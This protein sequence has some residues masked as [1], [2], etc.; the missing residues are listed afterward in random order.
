MRSKVR[1]DLEAHGVDTTTPSQTRKGMGGKTQKI[2][3][4]VETYS[5]GNK[6]DKWKTKRRKNKK[7]QTEYKTEGSTRKTPG[8][9]YEGGWSA[10]EQ[11]SRGKVSRMLHAAKG[12][13][14]P[15]KIKMAKKRYK[16]VSD[17]MESLYGD[18]E[19]KDL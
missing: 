16:D 12:K 9:T 18:W 19:T 7:G 10:D 4:E 14:A 13:Q 3:A 6:I 1:G 8:V 15:N 5:E 2:E 17:K 11:D